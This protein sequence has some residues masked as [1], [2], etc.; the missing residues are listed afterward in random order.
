MHIFAE[1]ALFDRHALLGDQVKIEFVPARPGDF[2]GKEINYAKA[3]AE[4]GWEPTIEFQ[5]GLRR[6]LD[7]FR[8]RWGP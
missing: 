2:R 3:R 1:D 8:E 5:D 7:W 6:T 4:L